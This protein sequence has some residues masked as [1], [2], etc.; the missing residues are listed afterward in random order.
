VCWSLLPLLLLLLLLMWHLRQDQDRLLAWQL[1]LLPLPALVM[2]SDLYGQLVALG[3]RKGLQQEPHCMQW[4]LQLH[5][6]HQTLHQ[7][8][9]QQQ[10][11]WSPAVRSQACQPHQQQVRPRQLHQLQLRPLQ[12]LLQQLQQ[13]PAVQSQGQLQLHQL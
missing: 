13:S 12:L 3:P 10:L 7:V 5:Q 6:V 11:H 1:L 2:C 9:L 4:L 8:L